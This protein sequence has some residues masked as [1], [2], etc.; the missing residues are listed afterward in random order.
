MYYLPLVPITKTVSP[1]AGVNR[2]G[3]TS[4][5]LAVGHGRSGELEKWEGLVFCSCGLTATSHGRQKYMA[6]T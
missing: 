3:S 5:G 2:A 4:E 6:E 1:P